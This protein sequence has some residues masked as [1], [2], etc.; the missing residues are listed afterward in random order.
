M[1]ERVDTFKLLGIN[2]QKNLKQNSYI[3]EIAGKRK[4]KFISSTG[5][6]KGSTP[7][8]SCACNLLHK[9]PTSLGISRPC[10]GWVTNLFRERN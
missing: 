6:Q 3:K 7:H 1:I 9:N 2:C 10:M 4:L 5:M 8:R